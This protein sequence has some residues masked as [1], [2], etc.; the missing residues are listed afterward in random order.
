MIDLVVRVTK[1]GVLIFWL[2]F[3]LSIT[4]II[5]PPYDLVITSVGVVVLLIHFAEF[6]LIKLGYIELKST[7]VSLLKTMLFGFTYW[8]PLMK[9]VNQ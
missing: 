1:Y 4:R 8:V 2:A 3:V 7:E 6:L 9:A 5:P